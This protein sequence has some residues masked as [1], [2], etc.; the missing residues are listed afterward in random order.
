MHKNISFMWHVIYVDVNCAVSFFISFTFQYKPQHNS[1]QGFFFLYDKHKINVHKQQ[2][3]TVDDEND[4]NYFVFP[5]YIVTDFYFFSHF[6]SFN[7]IHL[8]FHVVFF[9]MS[10]FFFFIMPSLCS[11]VVTN[12]FLF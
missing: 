10:C 8:L 3:F 4:V 7:G 12:G 11:V 2:P 5:M 6:L 9:F 1:Q